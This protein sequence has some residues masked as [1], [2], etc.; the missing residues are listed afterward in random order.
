MRDEDKRKINYVK[1][2]LG[3]YYHLKAKVIQSNFEAEAIQAKINRVSGGS[4]AIIPTEEREHNPHWRSP[5]FEELEYLEQKIDNYVFRYKQVEAFLSRLQ[6]KDR[7]MIYN[8]HVAEKKRK[9]YEDYCY[10][11]GMS[12]RT[13][14]RYIERLILK[15]WH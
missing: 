6:P 13:F 12:R 9:T 3:N 11:V 1:A 8:L 10:S 14:F 4:P 15:N 5:L 7:E 2:E